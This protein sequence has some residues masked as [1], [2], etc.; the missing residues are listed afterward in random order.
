MD[1]SSLFTETATQQDTIG[2]QATLEG[3]L[4]TGWRKKQQDYYQQNGSRRR[5]HTWAASV[6][7]ALLCVSHS[8]WNVR[9]GILHPRGANGRTTAAGQ[10]RDQLVEELLF[11]DPH[12]L[13]AADQHLMTSRTPAQI[14]HLSSE[15]Q[16][17]WINA[18]R[19]AI[20]AAEELRNS[21]A[22]NQRL[23]MAAWLSG[24]T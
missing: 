23:H 5:A 7:L 22:G 16:D 24:N 17:T 6:S 4:A 18:L 20:D 15:D 14:R 1:A 10:A 21:T 8:M 9:N 13:L 19:L 2:W 3:K 11:T 12:N